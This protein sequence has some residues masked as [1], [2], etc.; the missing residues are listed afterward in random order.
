MPWH[1]SGS[2]FST[3]DV[4]MGLQDAFFSRILASIPDRAPL[5]FLVRW[6]PVSQ[7]EATHLPHHFS[8]PAL[9][10]Y[11]LSLSKSWR[12]SQA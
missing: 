4:L 6:L 8:Q 2:R 3:N 12:V 9:L 5:D 10:C 11:G 1:P 7:A